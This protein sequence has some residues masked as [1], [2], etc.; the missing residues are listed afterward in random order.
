LAEVYVV[1]A[2]APLTL[3][4]PPVAFVGEVTFR[5]VEPCAPGAIVN[6][7]V[8]IPRAALQPVGTAS[9]KWN[10]DELQLELSLFLTAMTYITVVPGCTDWL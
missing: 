5:L 10:V 8:D 2:A 9:L 3:Y 6:D 7:A 1:F 4:D